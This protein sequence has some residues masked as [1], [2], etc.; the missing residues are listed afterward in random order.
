LVPEGTACEDETLNDTTVECRMVG[1]LEKMWKE[2][3]VA[4]NTILSL[5]RLT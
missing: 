3:T 1:R 4:A 5:A 2:A